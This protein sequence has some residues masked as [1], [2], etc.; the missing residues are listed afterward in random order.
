MSILTNPIL[1]TPNFPVPWLESNS[2]AWEF[3]VDRHSASRYAQ[4]DGKD[5]HFFTIGIC[6]YSELLPDK[7]ISRHIPEFHPKFS[8]LWARTVRFNRE[9]DLPTCDGPFYALQYKGVEAIVDYEP[10]PYQVWDDDQ[11]PPG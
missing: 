3:G 11:W 9:T 2:Q 7:T 5:E 6:G 10:L 4:F 8:W 1:T